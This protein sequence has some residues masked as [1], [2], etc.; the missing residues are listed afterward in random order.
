MTQFKGTTLCWWNKLGKT[1]IPNKLLQL[2]WNEFLILSKRK[3]CSAENMLELEN[4]LLNLKKG[5]MTV[6]EY[7]KIFTN[8]ME[9]VMCVVSNELYK[10]DKYAKGLP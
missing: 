6:E 1:I 4:Q 5:S 2:T 10:I 3:L 8:K 7:I 9:F